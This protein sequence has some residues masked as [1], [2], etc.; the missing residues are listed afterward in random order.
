MKANMIDYVQYLMRS[1]NILISLLIGGLTG[2]AVMF[3]FA[4]QSGKRTR[5]QISKKGNSFFDHLKLD[6]LSSIF[7][8]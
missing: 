8:K 6:R 7:E 2:A 1:K 5:A 4:P 3:L